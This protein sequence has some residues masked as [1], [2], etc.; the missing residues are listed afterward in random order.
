MHDFCYFTR[1]PEILVD[2]PFVF[3]NLMNFL[4]TQMQLAFVLWFKK[5]KRCW[6][7]FTA[8]VSIEQTRVATLMFG[9]LVR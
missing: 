5:H 3:E 9:L 2:L 7:N 6:P 4:S 8:F 1:S